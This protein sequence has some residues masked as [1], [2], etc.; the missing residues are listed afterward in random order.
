MFNVHPYSAAFGIVEEIRTAHRVDQRARINNDVTRKDIATMHTPLLVLDAHIQAVHTNRLQEARLA[1][2]AR[3]ARQNQ[4]GTAT[5]L[6]AVI[7]QITGGA[8]VTAG[9][10]LRREPVTR[11]VA[12]ENALSSR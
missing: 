8:L 5:R 12:H 3:L 10:W 9:Q 4:A 11:N 7:R 6:I 2:L 1:E